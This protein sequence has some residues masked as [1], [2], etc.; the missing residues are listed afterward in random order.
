MPQGKQD[1]L[2][3]KLYGRIGKLISKEARSGGADPVANI[4]L[5]LILR[6]AKQAGV[7][8]DIIA[9]NLAR[10]QDKTQGDFSEVPRSSRS[11]ALSSL[12]PCKKWARAR[13]A[14]MCH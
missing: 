8:N 11:T 1:N 2:K 10:G 3:A 9:R 13:Q 7:P 5:G 4:R 14:V 12:L 6:Q